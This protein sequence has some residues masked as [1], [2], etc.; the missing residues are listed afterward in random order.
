MNGTTIAIAGIALIP[1]IIALIQFAKRVVPGA[2]SR[3]WLVTSLVLGVSGQVAVYII[4]EGIPESFGGCV[5]L[6]VL[7]LAFGLAAS[8]AYDE[9]VKSRR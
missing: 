2:D 4:S 5:S 3:V 7:G 8:K 1:L 9:T 6:V